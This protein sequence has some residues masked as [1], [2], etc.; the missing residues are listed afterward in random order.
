[1]RAPLLLKTGELIAKHPI[2]ALVLTFLLALAVTV[3]EQTL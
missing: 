3:I 1:M 2:K